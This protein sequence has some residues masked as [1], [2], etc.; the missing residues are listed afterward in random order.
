MILE[1]RK[2]L[3]K[4]AGSY[5]AYSTMNVGLMMLGIKL[6]KYLARK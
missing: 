4:A 2:T 1:Y 5:V 6:G 3:L